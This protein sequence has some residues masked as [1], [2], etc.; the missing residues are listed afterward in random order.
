LDVY[1][2]LG[3][4][5]VALLITFLLTTYAAIFRRL[6]YSSDFA[7]FTLAVWSMLILYNLT[8]AAFQAG[9][10]WMLLMAGTV[11]VQSRAG[12]RLKAKSSAE[13]PIAPAHRQTAHPDA[14]SEI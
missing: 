14:I 2:N 7:I 4:V 13:R 1:L 6:K 10:L 3:F 9:L 5:G 11:T 12:K 8:E